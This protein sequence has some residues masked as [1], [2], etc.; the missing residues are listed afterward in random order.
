MPTF[1]LL[2]HE[3][4]YRKLSFGL[5]LAAVAVAAALLVAGPTIVSGY[6]AQ[7]EEEILAQEQRS[8]EALDAM[9]AETAR[10]LEENRLAAARRLAKLDK[11]TKRTMRDLGFNL[12]IVH[13]D[14]DMTGLYTD[15]VAKD[16][17]EEYVQRL[18][19][20]P[21]L[22]KVAHLV[23]KLTQKIKW[24]DRTRLL[25]GYSP[26][27]V[28]IHLDK[29]L[30]MGLLIKRGE[31]VLGHEAGIGHK[32]GEKVEILE[33]E[34]TITQI[35]PESAGTEDVMIAVN[36]V[37]AQELLDKPGK[38]T[39][40]AAIN[41]RC[42]TV[43][44]LAEIRDQ[45]QMVLP[46]TKITE[47]EAG[48]VAREEQRHSVEQTNAQLI[49]GYVAQRQK[50]LAD[51]E[52]AQAATL[53]DMKQTRQRVQNTLANLLWI[54]IPLV[55]LAAAAVIGLV[56]W[57]NVRERRAEIGLLRA[58]GRSTGKIAALFL[59]KAM[60]VG[61]IGGALGCLA[62]YLIAV[63]IAEGQLRVQPDHLSVSTLLL[64]AT[65]LGA[66]LVAVAA[67]F[68]P[69]RRAVG[70]DPSAALMEQ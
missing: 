28:Q 70:Q 19:T 3:I 48:A 33:R 63:A 43:D 21:E 1:K 38:I 26:E 47:W 30:P 37:D 20:S 6:A 41:C 42:E 53:A 16:M 60:L 11:D 18:A 49:A 4:C 56:T 69:T 35:R 61:A 62:G 24:E 29:K 68:P 52:A 57:N 7:T 23:A 46:E 27:A 67:S 15:F 2:V 25:I 39:E 59:G 34:F 50:I 13:R 12:R 66:P 54:T 5:C 65:L 51:E 10:G 31:V 14:T 8:T 32:V 58:L 9:R 22:T 36:L 55:V 44:R 45:L 64:V 17:P 40:I